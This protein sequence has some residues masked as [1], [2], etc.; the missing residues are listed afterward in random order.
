VSFPDEWKDDLIIAVQQTHWIHGIFPWGHPGACN[1]MVM[2][3][4]RR[5]EK[6]LATWRATRNTETRK[7][8]TRATVDWA[9]KRDRWM[10]LQ[11]SG[12]YSEDKRFGYTARPPMLEAGGLKGEEL[13]YSQATG[14][15]SATAQVNEAIYHV[16]RH[17]NRAIE[18]NCYYLLSIH[19]AKGGHS[20]GIHIVKD[21]LGGASSDFELIENRYLVIPPQTMHLFDPNVGEYVIEKGQSQLFVA[22]L[23]SNKYPGDQVKTVSV[24]HIPVWWG[25]GQEGQPFFYG[26]DD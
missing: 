1:T 4:F 20:I 11:S 19:G 18:S 2:D 10:R 5:I 14:G 26:E 7:V 23:L 24:A 15:V 6:G 16:W 22:Q 9:R 21:S 17:R 3:W 25:R 13:L 12:K 8:G